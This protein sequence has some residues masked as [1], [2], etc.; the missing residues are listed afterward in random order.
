M[1]ISAAL[2]ALPYVLL[3]GIA[4]WL[5]MALRRG[6]RARQLNEI[7]EA[8]LDELRETIKRLR[9]IGNHTGD[10]SD[11][12]LSERMLKHARRQ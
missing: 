3:G 9:E 5:V 7:Y 10:L 12:E 1:A 2:S 6:A 8:E 4:L 11:G